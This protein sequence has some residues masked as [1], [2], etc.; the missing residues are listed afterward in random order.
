MKKMQDCDF[1]VGFNNK[2]IYVLKDRNS[3]SDEIAIT[4][5]EFFHRLS[6]YSLYLEP[7]K[8]FEPLIQF[9]YKKIISLKCFL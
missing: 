2:G 5:Q 9:M 7:I 6:D 4:F 8:I 1:V 3:F